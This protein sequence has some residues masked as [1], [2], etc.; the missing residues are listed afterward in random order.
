MVTWLI[1]VAGK[2][3]PE[4][5][6]KF[7]ET[8]ALMEGV[9]LDKQQSVMAGRVTALFKVCLP[10]AHV[11]FSRKV[12]AEYTMKGLEVISVEALSSDKNEGRYL[13]LELNGQYRF[14]IDFDIRTILEAHG[15]QIEQLNQHYM[16]QSVADKSQFCSKVRAE[17]TR[18]ISKPDLLQAL[19]RLSPVLN[20][21]LSIDEPDSVLAS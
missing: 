5:L 18:P 1:T 13:V 2:D 21:R 8:I 14:G 9:F 17:L 20:I 15:A 7:C 4:L 11:P 10:S 19:Y 6:H 12:F 16:G 3:Q